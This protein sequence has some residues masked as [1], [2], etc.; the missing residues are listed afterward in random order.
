MSVDFK[1]CKGNVINV[2]IEGTGNYDILFNG[3]PIAL[4]TVCQMME[5]IM[6]RGDLTK[7]D[8]RRK[9]RG[10][11]KRLRIVKGFNPGGKRYSLPK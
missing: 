2:M 6:I 9:F 1:D 3:R 11:M 7:G 8:P 10:R 5:Y 4:S